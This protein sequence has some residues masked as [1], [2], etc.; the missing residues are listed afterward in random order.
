MPCRTGRSFEGVRVPSVRSAQSRGSFVTCGPVTVPQRDA[1][2][3]DV[4]HLLRGWSAGWVI[5]LPCCRAETHIGLVLRRSEVRVYRIGDC[6]WGRQ[7]GPSGFA[8]RS[9]RLRVYRM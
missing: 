1:S 8:V 7:E 4:A 6:R 5:S 2:A 3:D 9:N